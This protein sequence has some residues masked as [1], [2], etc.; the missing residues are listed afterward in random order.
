MNNPLQKIISLLIN[1]KRISK[2]KI[3]LL[4]G[5]VAIS[6]LSSQVIAKVENIDQPNLASK[7]YIVDLE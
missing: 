3:D 7:G 2:N 1:S 4:L 6:A 5:A